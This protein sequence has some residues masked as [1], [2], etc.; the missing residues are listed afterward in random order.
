MLTFNR[1][2]WVIGIGIVAILIL[3]L[4]VLSQ[5]PSYTQGSSF[6][7]NPG[8][9]AAWF[10]SMNQ[11]T[12]VQRWL[13]PFD[14]LPDDDRITL[15]QVRS[16]QISPTLFGTE[17]RLTAAE[18]QWVPQGNTLVILGLRQAATAAPFFS[19]HATE[20]G[21]VNIATSQRYE[22][23][24]QTDEI[25]LEDDYGAIAW[26][27][28]IGAGQVIYCVTPF[29]GAN[30]YLDT[31]GNFTLLTQWVRASDQPVWIDDYRHGYRE[32]GSTADTSQS[33]LGYLSATPVLP[34]LVQSGIVVGLAAWAATRR[35]GD[36]LPGRSPQISNSEAYV[37]ALA[38]VLEKAN[39]TEFIIDTI[40][41][42]EQQKLQRAL[43]LGSKRVS[44]PTL[45][46][47]WQAQ[48][49]RSVDELNQVLQ[50]MSV[51][52]RS[53]P[54]QLASQSRRTPISAK[55][56]ES[57]LQTFQSIQSQVIHPSTST[58]RHL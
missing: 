38:R 18:R 39:C 56:L 15:V 48:T 37:E 51:S 45:M 1:R 46:Q 57:W 32:P 8:G 40:G 4:S 9:Y 33:V 44:A 43:G 52:G 28:Q 53:E 5:R 13:K 31:P 50:L 19:T 49:G 47:A 29:I 6:S 54:A 24:L 17:D 27:T 35:L 26:R 22:A 16:Q 25:L 14:Q 21:D 2:R 7:L 55:Q 11:H 23:P 58:K 41:P 3:G 34:M 36:P 30:A 42:V 12:S 10:D 20:L